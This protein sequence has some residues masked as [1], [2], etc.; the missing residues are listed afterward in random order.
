M[1]NSPDPKLLRAAPIWQAMHQKALESGR[2][3]FALGMALAALVYQNSYSQEHVE[4]LAATFLQHIQ[5]VNQL[6]SF[7]FDELFEIAGLEK[8]VI[9]NAMQSVLAKAGSQSASDNS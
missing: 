3:E 7:G 4:E 8:E 2:L 1:S 5:N 9:K 6:F